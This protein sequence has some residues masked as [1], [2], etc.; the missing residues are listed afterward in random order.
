V[1]LL[2]FVADEDAGEDDEM[3]VFKKKPI[4]LE[5]PRAVV[6]VPNS[7][8]QPSFNVAKEIS[9]E[10]K[11]SKRHEDTKHEDITKIREQ[12]AKEQ[13]AGGLSRKA[14]IEKWRLKSENFKDEETTVTNDLG[15]N[16]KA[17]F[18]T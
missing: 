5:N 8:S 4:V 6:A 12:H 17:I 14:E 15:H 7:V 13:A 3:V 2:S 1:K 18:P 9:K 16:Q 10:P 11:S